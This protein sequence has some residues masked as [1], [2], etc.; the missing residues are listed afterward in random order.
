MQLVSCMHGSTRRAADAGGSPLAAAAAGSS[1][2]EPL[3][4]CF[5]GIR[6]C[7]QAWEGLPWTPSWLACWPHAT[8]LPPE[9]LHYA[10]A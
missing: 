7:P 5:G 4:P 3:Q 9:A 6:L 2:V 1:L 8:S 10:P